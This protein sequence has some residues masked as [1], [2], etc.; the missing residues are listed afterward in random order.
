M[1]CWAV[2][3]FGLGFF[4]FEVLSFSWFWLC[5]MFMV[6]GGLRGGLRRARRDVL[7]RFLVSFGGKLGKGKIEFDRAF[8]GGV[9]GS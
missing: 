7:C 1:C 5:V 2:G 4:F 6:F 3:E 9:L 8:E